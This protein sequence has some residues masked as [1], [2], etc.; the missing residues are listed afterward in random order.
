NV[1]LRNRGRYSRHHHFISPYEGSRKRNYVKGKINEVIE[2][3]IGYDGV[4]IANSNQ[5]HRFD[6]TKKDLFET[7]SAYSQE[8]DKLVK[9]NK[10]FWSNVNQALP[11]T[12]IEIYGPHQNRY[13]R[14]FG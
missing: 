12:E 7:L 14:N 5:S 11:K 3:I 6:F 8:N 9:N 13:I 1:L 10:K 2:I 4:V